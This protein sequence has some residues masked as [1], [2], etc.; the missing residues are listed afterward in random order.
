MNKPTCPNIAPRFLRL[1]SRGSTL[2]I[3]MVLTIALGIFL[4]AMMGR[5]HQEQRTTDRNARLH[6]AAN[7]AESLGNYGLAD[8]VRRYVTRAYLPM[9]EFRANPLTIPGNDFFDNT[10]I[11]KPFNELIG[12]AVPTAQRVF[13][14]PRNPANANDPLVRSV[15]DAVNINVYSRAQANPTLEPTNPAQS[16]LNQVLQVRFV[17]LTDAL[18]YNM[19]L[20][21]HPGEL[22]NFRGKVHSNNDI[23]VMAQGFP[24]LYFWDTVT[25]AGKILHLYK[26]T[27]DQ[28]PSHNQ[29]VFFINNDNAPVTMKLNESNTN[30]SWVY[31]RTGYDWLGESQRRW[32]ANVQDEAHGVQTRNPAGIPDYVEDNP[33]TAGNELENHAYAVIEPLLLSTHS[34]RKTP[35]GRHQKFNAR[36]CLIFRVVTTVPGDPDYNAAVGGLA[37]RA[38]TFDRVNTSIPVNSQSP[39]D[40]NIRLNAAGD[41]VELRV[42]LPPGLIGAMRNTGLAAAT[43]VQYWDTD[44]NSLQ[45]YSTNTVIDVANGNA[46]PETWVGNVTRGMTDRRQDLDLSPITIDIHRLR[47]LVDE[48]AHPT[49]TSAKMSDFWIDPADPSR[50]PTF[51]P[52]TQWNGVIYVEFPL[53]SSARRAVDGIVVADVEDYGAANLNL[54]LQVAHGE[55][56]PNPP[57]SSL[58]VSTVFPLQDDV[59]ASERYATPNPGFTLATNGPLYLIG[60]YNSDGNSGTG[61]SNVPDA[62]VDA[63][64]RN[65]IEPPAG[66]A[67]DSFTQLSRNWLACGQ[68]LNEDQ[69]VDAIFGGGPAFVRNRNNS[70]NG[71]RTTRRAAFTE[72]SAAVIT[73]LI[74]TIPGSGNISG[75]A[76]NFPR[77]LEDWGSF[78]PKA[79]LRMRTSL[80][81]LF[82]SEAHLDPMPNNQSYYKP[83]V[84]NWGQPSM[85]TY[86]SLVL[87]PPGWIQVIDFRMGGIIPMTEAEYEAAVSPLR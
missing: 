62:W 12:G 68:D 20:E 47:E 3:V 38:F 23:Y 19:D 64:G 76:H 55:T 50:T 66:I 61:E 70:A 8:I 39:F 16:F 81:A 33:A 25:A 65:Y 49:R 79:E 51:D 14:D 24:G 32:D 53:E 78:S 82:Q 29:P 44:T 34:N 30:S 21:L 4:A 72:V 59:I 15:I 75:G 11:D 6:E 31:N 71:D 43:N 77:F 9:N 56:I 45:T 48:R 2:V 80:N 83:P 37:V 46:I 7:A 52:Q 74:P 57:H 73:G 84:R 13:I 27:E 26:L 87:I 35:A 58:I 10:F 60:N 17:N 85:I 18:F 69:L 86:P 40:G 42:Y 41:P 28:L 1:R 5:G 36:A 63:K 22:M 67:C 54:A